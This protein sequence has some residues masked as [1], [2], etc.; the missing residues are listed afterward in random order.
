MIRKYA[1]PPLA[2]LG[3]ALAI[4]TVIM[5]ARP[6]PAAAPVAEPSRAPFAS[7][8]AG[9][10]LVEASSENI[11]AAT[12]VPGLVVEVL[13]EVGKPVKAG[14]PLLRLDDRDVRAEIEVRKAMIEAARQKLARVKSLPRPED[15]PPLEARLKAAEADAQNMQDQLKRVESMPDKRA[16]SEEDLSRR[17]FASLMADARVA[18]ARSQLALVK[19]G[20]WA[21]DILVAESEIATTESQLRASEVALERLTVRSPIDGEILQ[22]NVRPG[23]YALTASPLVV[24]GNTDILH[25]R[26][27]I[28]ENDAWR[29][30]PGAAAVAFVR[31]NKELNAKLEFV[32]VEPY[33]VPKRSLTG[34][35]IERVDTRVMQ[36]LFK[37]AKSALPVYVGQQM[38]VSIEAPPVAG[39]K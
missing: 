12:P 27:D 38:D 25:V 9:A 26:V 3:V 8:M 11:E 2:L 20:A 13:V 29:F 31:G 10:G 14:A 15:L 21:P 30:K 4:W 28:D 1:L 18:E 24:L 6:V 22:V 33:V 23:E 7:Y 5:G 35:S 39:S 17:K 19:A 16:M 37:F 32:R 34:S 36:V